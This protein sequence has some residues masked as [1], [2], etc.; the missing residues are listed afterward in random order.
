MKLKQH[1]SGE[2]FQKTLPRAKRVNKIAFDKELENFPQTRLLL[3]SIMEQ[4]D[5]SYA[6]LD[7]HNNE[8]ISLK[9]LNNGDKKV[10]P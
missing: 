3:K 6:I 4:I 2:D 9:G 1:M 8:I 10:R 7:L 5:F